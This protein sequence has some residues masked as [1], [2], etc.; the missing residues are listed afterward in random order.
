[1]KK[2]ISI[3]ALLLMAVS[4]MQAQTRPTGA[5]PGKFTVAELGEGKYKKVYFSQGNLQAVCTTADGDGSTPETCTWRFATNQ[6]DNVGSVPPNTNDSFDGE[7][8]V[9]TAGTVDL[10]RWVGENSDLA[11]YGINNNSTAENY[12]NV[13]GEA[14]KSDWGTTMGDGWF[15]L[16]YDEWTYLIG[17]RASGS[18]VNGT[19]NARYAVAT[20][21]T[22]G[23][24]VDGLI[25][26]PD[27][28]TIGSSEATSWG[29]INKQP[30][31]K[32]SCT[33]AQWTALAAKGCVFLPTTSINYATS[34]SPNTGT[35]QWNISVSSSGQVSYSTTARTQRSAVRLVILAPDEKPAA[36]CTPPTAVENLEYTGSPQEL[37][38]AG[39]TTEGTM[40]YSLDGTNWDYDNDNLPTATDANTD[41]YT[42]YYKVIG[43]ADHSDSDPA[44]INVPIAQASNS[45]TSQP[46]I[47]GWTYGD[48]ANAPTGTAAFGTITYKYCATADGTYDTYENVVNGNAGTWYVKGFV[49]ATTNY[50]ATESNAVEFAIAKAAA[51]ATAPA[52]IDNLTYDGTDQELVTPGINEGGEWQYKIGDDEYSNAT[53]TGNAVGDYTIY[54][55]FVG[56]DNHNNIDEASFVVNIDYNDD[57][58]AANTVIGLIAAIGEVEYTTECKGK[59]DAAREAY[60]GLEDETQKP[61][62]GN[63]DVLTAAESSY[64]VLD[65]EALITA[66]GTTIMPGSSAAITA[67]RE[68]YDALTDAQKALVGDA[69]LSTLTEAEAVIGVVEAIDAIGT[70]EYTTECKEKIDAARAAYDALNDE[71]QQPLVGNY[72]TLTDAETAYATLKATADGAAA[73]DVIDLINAIGT[74]ITSASSTAITAA[75]TAYNALTADQQALVTNSDDLTYAETALTTLT[76]MINAEGNDGL[77]S[78]LSADPSTG[79]VMAT[80]DGTSTTTMAIGTDVQVDEIILNRTFTSGTAA[81]LM[82]PFSLND[83]ATGQTL[84]GGT[85]YKFVGVAKD[86]NNKWWATMETATELKAN[87]PY[88]F[89]PNDALVEGKVTF[90]LNGAPVTMNTTTAASSNNLDAS[91]WE[92]YGSYAERHWY[93]DDPVHDDENADEIGVVYGFAAKNGTASDG[94]SAI[95]AGQFVR[96]ANGAWLRPLRCYL[97][98]KGEGNPLAARGRAAEVLPESIGIRLVDANGK[99]TDLDENLRVIGEDSESSEWYSL[100]GRKLAGKPGVKGL[101][102]KNGNKVVIK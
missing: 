61:L 89:L 99:T 101:Y 20:I 42:V 83:G 26:F 28:V 39:S 49:E 27:E 11:P 66:I 58:K 1:M 34:T 65:V 75:R 81:T 80:I 57:Q 59:I 94:V 24:S 21:N 30:K 102:I 29:N 18:T 64:A 15:T 96:F 79:L 67:A 40:K 36:T 74:P 84:T 37:I 3:L 68:A 85:L 88:V 92:F 46:T 45:F 69:N 41:G 7:N 53:P 48:A 12:G 90:D 62:V 72:A 32:T 86:A 8:S 2:V 95:A 93:K 5:L 6:W 52:A 56:D 43:D 76:D 51:T 77:A 44:S 22:D 100:G 31:A 73:G 14:L 33:T 19:S 16:A 71:T 25:L 63:Y 38:N 91:N 60:N 4:G 23:T 17:S 10:F 70:V 78:I 50:T 97:M 55:K 9:T 13:G 82:L 54:Y 47:T 98:F 87:T 35:F